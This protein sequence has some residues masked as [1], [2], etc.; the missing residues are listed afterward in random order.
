MYK[1]QKE[2]WGSN[3]SNNDVL[4]MGVIP[5]SICGWVYMCPLLPT[6]NKIIKDKFMFYLYVLSQ[7]MYLIKLS[8]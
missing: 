4:F 1:V 7:N 6:Y 3:N 8:W 5:T 2:S